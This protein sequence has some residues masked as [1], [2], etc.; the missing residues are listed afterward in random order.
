MPSGRVQQF[1]DNI[2]ANLQGAR[3]YALVMGSEQFA[4][5]EV[6]S[7]LEQ[8][9]AEPGPTCSVPARSA[10][11]QILD[12]DNDKL[13]LAQGNYDLLGTLPKGG[14]YLITVSRPK[15]SKGTSR[16][17]MIVTIR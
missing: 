10:V 11:F 4:D 14:D 3:Y 2:F 7:V 1:C 9:L 16:Y 12:P 8:V 5:G 6:L 17:K 15:Q 13:S